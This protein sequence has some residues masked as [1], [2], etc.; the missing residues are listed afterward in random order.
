MSDPQPYTFIFTTRATGAL[1]H[2]TVRITSDPDANVAAYRAKWPDEDYAVTYEAGGEL[3][4]VPSPPREPREPLERGAMTVEPDEV[5]LARWQR[6]VVAEWTLYCE[7]FGLGILG[8]QKV[9]T[10]N[11]FREILEWKR[12]QPESLWTWMWA[13]MDEYPEVE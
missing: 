10:N 5:Q 11:P 1:H 3:V 2:Q 8:T 9:R 4:T 13:R 7:N 6:P 12:E